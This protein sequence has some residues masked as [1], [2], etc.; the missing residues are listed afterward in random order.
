MLARTALVVRNPDTYSSAWELLQRAKT[1]L[2][3]YIDDASSETGIRAKVDESPG[4]HLT[5]ANYVRC[6][7]GA[8]YNISGTLYQADRISHAIRFLNEGCELSRRALCMR[9]MCSDPN[10]PPREGIKDRDEEGWVQL[11]EQ[12]WRR[13]EILG[14][15][16]VKIGDR[17]VSA[18]SVSLINRLERSP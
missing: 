16:L 3:W 10:K 5:L 11:E 18:V 6:L 4:H 1:M 7:S 17:R 2:F 12:I 14:A 13:W 9:R 8:F 15:C